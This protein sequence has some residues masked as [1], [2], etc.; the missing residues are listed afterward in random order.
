VV[1]G[2]THNYLILK[3]ELSGGIDPVE[4]VAEKL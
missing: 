3:R 4:L 1:E 2:Q